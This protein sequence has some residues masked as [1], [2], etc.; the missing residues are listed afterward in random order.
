[1]QEDSP[2]RASRLEDWSFLKQ[3]SCDSHVYFTDM[4]NYQYTCCAITYKATI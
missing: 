3:Q 4:H 1:M 2:E